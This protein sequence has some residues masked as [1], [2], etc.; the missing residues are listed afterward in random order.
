MSL[1]LLYNVENSTNKEQPL[2]EYVC[3]NF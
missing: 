3:P 2:N 1:L